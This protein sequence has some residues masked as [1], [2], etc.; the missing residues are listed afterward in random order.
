[1]ADGRLLYPFRYRDPVTRK[2]TRAR[3]RASLADIAKRHADWEL[4]GEPEY[5]SG[6]GAMFSPFRRLG[7]EPALDVE[8]QLHPSE[9]WLVA[10]FLRRYVTWCARTR[11]LGA[12][13][14][15]ARLLEHVMNRET[16]HTSGRA[17]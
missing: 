16:T 2:W 15:A 7:F 3:Y 8:P 5:R 12:M 11:R 14:G 17:N 13:Q 10:C 6:D 1:M 9:A 4:I